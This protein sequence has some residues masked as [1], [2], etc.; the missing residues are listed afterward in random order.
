LGRPSGFRLS[1]RR[2]YTNLAAYH[3]RMGRFEDA[4]RESRRAM[5]LTRPN[6]ADLSNMAYALS[7][8][9][10]YSEAVDAARSAVRL[11]PGNDKARYL[12]GSLLVMDW[13][14]IRE[15]ITQLERVVGSVPAAQASLDGAKKTL[16]KCEVSREACRF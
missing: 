13:R 4:I 12:L 8:L 1:S 6:A 11:E 10:R 16:S 15:G 3:A 5:E 14:T 2:R 9:Q 7:R